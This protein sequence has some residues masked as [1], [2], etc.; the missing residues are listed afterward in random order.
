MALSV[1]NER[2]WRGLCELLGRPDLAD[3][4]RF[5]T[6]ARREQHDA[7]DAITEAWTRTRDHY[8]AMRELQEAGVPAGPVLTTAE[9]YADPH[10]LARG[11]FEEVVDPDAGR[12]RYPGRPGG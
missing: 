3:D 6:A 8:T 10:L 12:H 9:V 1:T 2:E 5:A 7:L 4:S 11:F